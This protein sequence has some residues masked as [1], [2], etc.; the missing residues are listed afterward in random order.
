MILMFNKGHSFFTLLNN[1]KTRLTIVLVK[2]GILKF[3]TKLKLFF[4]KSCRFFFISVLEVLYEISQCRRD[5]D[6]NIEKE[7]IWSNS[8]KMNKAMIILI[9]IGSKSRQ[10]SASQHRLINSAYKISHQ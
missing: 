7:N 4:N 5:V 9:V 2:R 10:L 8:V 1:L 6:L 3:H